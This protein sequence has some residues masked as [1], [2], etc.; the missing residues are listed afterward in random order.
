MHAQSQ[1]DQIFPKLPL[2]PSTTLYRE[3]CSSRVRSLRKKRIIVV[4]S[5]TVSFKNVE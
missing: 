5:K 4:F 1:K 3:N 2:L